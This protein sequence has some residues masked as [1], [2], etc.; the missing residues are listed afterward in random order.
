ML[1]GFGVVTLVMLAAGIWMLRS[2]LEF[3][4][5]HVATEGTV[6]LRTD[7]EPTNPEGRGKRFAYVEFQ[8]E[9]QA[10][11]VRAPRSG[12]M[13]TLNRFRNGNRVQLWH[14]RGNPQAAQF[15]GDRGHFWGGVAFTTGGALFGFFWALML[16]A[17]FFPNQ[18]ARF[19]AGRG[20]GMLEDGGDDLGDEGEP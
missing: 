14:P 9:G 1:V 4:R 5:T 12:S 8:S 13:E 10:V 18:F 11:L 3:R 19:S 20:A 16:M 2:G 7:E 6:V 15:E 17:R